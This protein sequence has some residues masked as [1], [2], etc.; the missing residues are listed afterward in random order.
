M[1]SNVEG[2]VRR[3]RQLPSDEALHC[4]T[5]NPEPAVDLEHGQGKISSLDRA[6]DRGA[7]LAQQNGSLLH[8]E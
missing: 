7:A 5:G 6:V 4:S 2:L 3:A 8:T 1:I